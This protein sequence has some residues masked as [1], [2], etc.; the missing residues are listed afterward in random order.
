MGPR[1]ARD[2]VNSGENL[3]KRFRNSVRAVLTR[4]GRNVL[5]LRFEAHVGGSCK[6]ETRGVKSVRG[7]TRDESEELKSD[8]FKSDE[9]KS[10][11]TAGQFNLQTIFK[12]GL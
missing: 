3:S 4:E 10:S 6:R 8:D 11:S 5:N 1:D 12:F 9:F 7:K 2:A